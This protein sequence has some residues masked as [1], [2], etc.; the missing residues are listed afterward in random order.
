MENYSI[1]ENGKPQGADHGI[2]AARYAYNYSKRN[3]A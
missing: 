2:D 3:F 1:D